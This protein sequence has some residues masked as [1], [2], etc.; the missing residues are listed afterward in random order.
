M[1]VPAMLPGPHCLAWAP[2]QPA[3]V[4]SLPPVGEGLMHLG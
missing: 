1:S 3:W 4:V 2:V